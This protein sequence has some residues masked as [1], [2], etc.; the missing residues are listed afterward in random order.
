MAGTKALAEE[1]ALKP[2]SAIVLQQGASW[3]PIDSHIA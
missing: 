1:L 2:G 3:V